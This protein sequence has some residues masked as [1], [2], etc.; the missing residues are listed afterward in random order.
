MVTVVLVEMLWN[1]QET[2]ATN[3]KCAFIELHV[4]VSRYLS[5][6]NLSQYDTVYYCLEL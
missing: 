3:V 5:F 6:V 1:A 4:S 2:V